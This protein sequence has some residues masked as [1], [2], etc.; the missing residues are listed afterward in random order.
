MTNSSEERS[1]EANKGL[2]TGA[3][4]GLLCLLVGVLGLLIW[5]TQTLVPPDRAQTYSGAILMCGA[6]IV[7]VAFFMPKKSD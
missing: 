1:V 4:I 3:R 2:T 6:L 7:L 5:A